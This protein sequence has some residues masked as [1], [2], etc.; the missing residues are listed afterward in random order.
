MKPDIARGV[1]RLVPRRRRAHARP[2]STDGPATTAAGWP[3]GA[4]E[5]PY[6]EFEDAGQGGAAV[7]ADGDPRI[8]PN[9]PRHRAASSRADRDEA[10]DP[11]EFAE[12]L[13]ADDSPMPANPVFKERLRQQLWGM[14]RENADAKAPPVP[15][16][17]G[18]RPLRPRPDPKSKPTR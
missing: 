1:R 18:E 8:Q 13:E 5:D 12:F 14:V 11:A 7:A 9:G 2:D 4:V 10:F 15:P 3:P 6:L 16:R 17:I